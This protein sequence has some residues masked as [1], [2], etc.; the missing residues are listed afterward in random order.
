MQIP[1]RTEELRSVPQG[2]AQVY[3]ES[4]VSCVIA[5]ALIYRSRR[6][7]PFFS[8]S[9]CNSQVGQVLFSVVKIEKIFL[10]AGIFLLRQFKF[11]SSNGRE[12]K[13]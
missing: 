1:R 3:Q 13:M 12:E 11:L 9:L 8:T 6:S 4:C 7:W 5:H 10:I 2:K